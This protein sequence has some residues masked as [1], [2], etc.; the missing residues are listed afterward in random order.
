MN[1]TQVI[2]S[3]KRNI[4]SALQ[5]LIGEKCILVDVPYYHNIGDVLIWAGELNFI[6]QCDIKLLQSASYD[7][8]NFS[9]IDNETTILFQGGGNIGDL[10]HEH[11]EF[12]H[13]IIERYPN[14]R[15]I[16]FPQTVYY[17]NKEI[18]ET[19]FKKIAE[20]NDLYFCGRDQR[21]YEFLA[22]Y[23]GDNALCLPD[24]AFCIDLNFLSKYK[25]PVVKDLLQIV[26]HDC[27]QNEVEAK[28]IGE[29]CSDWPV[30]EHSLTKSTIINKIFSRIA[31]KK[32]P[33][34]NTLVNKVWDL[35]AQKVFFN[36][37]I[38]EGVRFISPYEK[39]QSIRLHGCI[40]SILLD[41]ETILVD[42]SYGKNIH[43]YKAWLT[44]LESL[45]VYND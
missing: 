21:T 43:F 24:M 37:M 19:D 23:L 1:N 2:N 29:F 44:E 30:Y 4:Y 26:R 7:T 15:I 3:L 17:K 8:F 34:L 45:T 16:V 11:V 39:V 42:N 36:L 6:K 27:E 9:K 10:Y 33:V 12:L 31:K 38:K 5:P 32:I 35:Y 14:N 20:H 13:E 40:L 28:D 22:T 18:E 41:K 25:K